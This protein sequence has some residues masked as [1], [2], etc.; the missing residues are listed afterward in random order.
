MGPAVEPRQLAGPIEGP[1]LKLMMLVAPRPVARR[2]AREVHAC[3]A[4]ETEDVLQG[5]HGELADRAPRGANQVP[6]DIAAVARQV[7]AGV[8][9]LLV[10]GPLVPAAR[11]VVVVRAGVDDA[12]D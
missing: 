11:G 3:L 5:S 1:R 4:A 12:A 9:A 6:G 2:P 8:I 10:G 7:A